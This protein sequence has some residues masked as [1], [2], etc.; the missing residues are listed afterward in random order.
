MGRHTEVIG[1]SSAAGANSY[2]AL[3]NLGCLARRRGDHASA[4]EFFQRS[5]ATKPHKSRPKLEVAAELR[6]LDRLDEAAAL[7]RS[8]LA[9]QP[10][11]VRA[12]AGLGRIA[13]A[14]GELRF[15]IKHYKDAV[16]ANP[17]RI[18]L[19]LR[20]AAQLHK[21]SR[22]EEARRIYDEIVKEQP[23]NEVARAR[24][25]KLPKPR[26][27][28]L[29]PFDRS[30]LQ[31][32]TFT[33]ADAW[34]GNLEA[35][36]IPAFGVSLLTLAQDFASGASEE[37]KRD[38]ILIRRDDKTRILP[39]VADPKEFQHIVEREVAA[40]PRASLLG[41]VADTR[42]D[43]SRWSFDLEEHHHEFVY[44]RESAAAM[45]GPALSKY[46]QEVRRLVRSGA[47]L[48]PIGPDNLERVLACNDRWYAGKEQRGRKTY[49][50]R[51]TLW[52]FENL[53]A[54][55]PLHSRHLAVVLDDDVIGY[56][57]SSHIGKSWAVFVYRRCDREPPGIG[58]YLLSEMSKLY[59][60]REWINDGPAVRKPGLA[61][62]KERFTV[63]AGDRQMTLGWI[64][65]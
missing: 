52:T 21:L 61:W 1:H 32:D 63:N 4:L 15:A 53:S 39:L 41:Y 28:G 18:D 10:T 6:K 7:Y 45:V 9:D 25:R 36:K 65:V 37:V 24:L 43:G 58:P 27:S 17:A 22:T 46:R 49:Y 5:L 47:H 11:L 19:K 30:W 55:E 50:R 14:R 23:G 8:I 48:E 62:F 57:V 42:T 35:L 51:R 56:A 12:L 44:R 38:C 40:L 54:L 31:R 29:P 33:R 59:P 20:T 26:S 64:K 34:G 13:Q 16:A 3:I 60:D 2:R